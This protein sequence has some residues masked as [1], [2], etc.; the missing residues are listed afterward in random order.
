[1]P[2]YYLLAISATRSGSDFDACR[3]NAFIF[4]VTA[5]VQELMVA[6]TTPCGR[7]DGVNK[8]SH[9]VRRTDERAFRMGRRGAVLTLVT[10]VKNARSRVHRF[11]TIDS[12]NNRR[13]LGVQNRHHGVSCT[14]QQLFNFTR[15]VVFPRSPISGN[16]RRHIKIRITTS[17]CVYNVWTLFPETSNQ[18]YLFLIER[19]IAMTTSYRLK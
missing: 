12:S 8:A 9:G 14:Y 18:L 10:F 15:S 16:G 13:V 1:M 4:H 7:S 5:C 17:L 11:D 6:Q 19:H 3:H 2:N